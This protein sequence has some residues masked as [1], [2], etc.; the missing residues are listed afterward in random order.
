MVV[1]RRW[2][3]PVTD[4]GTVTKVV[5]KVVT[6]HITRSVAREVK[7][8]IPATEVTYIPKIKKYRTVWVTKWITV[9][10]THWVTRPITRYIT[11]IV[12]RISKVVNRSGSQLPKAPLPLSIGENERVRPRPVPIKPFTGGRVT[13]PVGRLAQPQP[14]RFPLR[15]VA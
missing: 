7:V 15:E 3:E 11:Q 2:G 1:I 13:A 14:R 6:H 12:K 4:T 9:N 8:T 10:V 5:T